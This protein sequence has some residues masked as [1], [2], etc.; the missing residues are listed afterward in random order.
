VPVPAHTGE[1]RPDCTMQLRRRQGGFTLTELA[2]VF[3]IVVLLLGGAMMTLSAQVEQRN[4]DEAVRRLNAAAEAVLAFSI[5]NR[6]LPCPARFTGPASHSQGLESFCPGAAGA[7]VGTETTAVQAHGNCS[8]FFDGYLPAVALGV[9]PIDGLGF[10]VDPWSN[11]LR[12]A[13][14]GAVTGCTT[15]PGPPPAGTRVVTSQANLKTYGLSCRPNDLDVCTSAACTA[16]VVSTQ[17]AVFVVYSTGSNGSIAAGYGADETENTDGDAVFV[18]R[19]PS[20]SNSPLG[21]FDDHLFVM[22]AAV[23]YSRMISAGVLP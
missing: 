4:S 18:S 20:D 7:C 23:A 22:P 19:T 11:R 8:N 3:A 13:V 21:N 5:V 6:R 9:N 1:R 10:A 12:Y 15:P 2:V 16:R 14:S 17:T